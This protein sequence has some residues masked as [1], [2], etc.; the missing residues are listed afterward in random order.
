M[1]L[2]LPESICNKLTSKYLQY[3]KHVISS[4]TTT[5]NSSL[6]LPEPYNLPDIYQIQLII[7][8]INFINSLNDIGTL[9]TLIKIRLKELQTSNWLLKDFFSSNTLNSLKI[10]NNLAEAVLQ[11]LLWLNINISS[12]YTKIFKQTGGNIEI[13]HILTND[14]LYRKS[15]KSVKH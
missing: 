4:P 10:K 11:Q 15:L 6:A 8:T 13:K 5:P 12:P 7:H 2:F 3:F 14:N 1:N 9:G